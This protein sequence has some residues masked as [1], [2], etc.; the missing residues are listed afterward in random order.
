[1]AVPTL[2]TSEGLEY[3]L[4]SAIITEPATGVWRAE[5]NLDADTAVTGQVTIS[6]DGQT[7]VGTVIRSATE[8]GRVMALV[9]G[10]AGTLGADEDGLIIG[11]KSFTKTTLGTVLQDV[12]RLTGESLG[13]DSDDLSGYQV[14]LW[15]RAQGPA[16]RAVEALSKKSRLDWRVTREGKLWFGTIPWGEASTTGF[17]LTDGNASDGVFELRDAG[18]LEPGVTYQGE[19]IRQVVHRLTSGSLVTEAWVRSAGGA[20]AQ[21]REQMRRE[22][23]YDRPWPCEVISQR[24]DGT[25]ELKADDEEIAGTGLD[26]VPIAP[27]LPGLTVEVP[28]GARCFV[29]FAAGDPSRPRV[30]GWDHSTALTLLTVSNGGSTDFVALAGLVLT[31][32]QAIQT[33]AKDHTHPTGVGPSG[34]PIE[35]LAAPSSV[36]ASTLKAE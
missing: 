3:R 34:I 10:G 25:L 31:E 21:L 6:I 32:L 7:W 14:P 29:A 23:D 15:N 1:M 2:T 30:V 11:A 13:E 27:G 18:S 9:L 35:T 19:R 36:A 8:Q 4:L 16:R 5:T 24:S 33:W 28:A 12:L 22:T 26:Y 20:F 17:V